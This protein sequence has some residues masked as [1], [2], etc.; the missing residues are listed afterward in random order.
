M[1]KL[2][3][4]LDSDGCITNLAEKWAT[5]YNSKYQDNLP[6][7]AFRDWQDIERLVKPECG[8]AVFDLMKARGMFASLEPLPGAVECVERLYNNPRVDLYIL[9]SYSGHSE[10]AHGKMVYF[11][12][13]FPFLD[14]EKIILCKPKHLVFGHVLVDDCFDN[15]RDWSAF[16]SNNALHDHHTILISQAPDSLEKQNR[17]DAVV[18]TITDA[19]QYIENILLQD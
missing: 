2:I 8:S 18:P 5:Q 11:A 14:P 10:I 17:V 6:T 7:A 13:H 4:H 16:Q 19:V 3:V 9:T 1:E 12:K 15:L